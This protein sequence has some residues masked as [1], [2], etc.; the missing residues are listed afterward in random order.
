MHKGFSPKWKGKENMIMKRREFLASSAVASLGLGASGATLGADKKLAKQ[1]IELRLYTFETAEKLNAFDQFLAQAMIPAL[2]RAGVGPV[3]VFSVLK[4]DVA[5]ANMKPDGAY[6]YVLLPY[7]SAESFPT[8]ADKLNKDAVFQKAGAAV[9]ASPRSSPAYLRYESTIMLAFSN[10]PKVEVPSK[11]AT[12]VMQLRTYES[13]NEDRAKMK[14]HMF[15]EGGEI[16]TFRKCDLKIVFF[17]QSLAG[18]RLPNLTYMLGFDNEQAQEKAWETFKKDPDWQKISKDE[19]YK[20]T[21]S[22]ITNLI[23]RPASSSQI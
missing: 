11:A 16:A 13:H 9:L 14:I 23:L 1:L 10:M 20:D 8:L 18:A 5:K 7:K 4:G 21:V 19:L 15:N 12:R 22:N 3:G 17:G 6:L 2:N